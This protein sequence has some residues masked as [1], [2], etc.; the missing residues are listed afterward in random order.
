V[1]S[2]DLFWTAY[3]KPALMMNLLRYE[4]LGKER[5]DRA[6][7]AYT[8]AWA[9]KHPAPADFFRMMRNETGM[10]LDWFW[11]GWLYTTARLD[12]AVD[13]VTTWPDSA[14]IHLSN[15]GTMVMPAE[16]ALTFAAGRTETV[17][18]PVDMWNLGSRFTYRV[19][20]GGLREVVLDPR[21]VM[22][23]GDRSNNRWPLGH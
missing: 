7:R 22:P 4:V 20:G 8:A 18:L 23:D 17:R 15:R 21:E 10:D 6:F 14:A 1:E 5:F 12:Q 2:R 9:F 13:S 3:Q 19:R 11:R 16:L